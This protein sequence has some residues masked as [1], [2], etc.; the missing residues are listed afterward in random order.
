MMYHAGDSSRRERKGGE[1]PFFFDG[2]SSEGA[3]GG[4]PSFGLQS[5]ERKNKRSVSAVE[6]DSAKLKEFCKVKNKVN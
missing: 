3:E 2:G 5:E 6:S 1:P 4:T